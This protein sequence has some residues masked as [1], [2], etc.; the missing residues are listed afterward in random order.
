MGTRYSIDFNKLFDEND[1]EGM[2]R[3]AVQ[4]LTFDY[5]GQK[6][7]PHIAYERAETCLIK[8]AEKGYRDAPYFLAYQ[9][10]SGNLFKRD[11]KKALYWYEKAAEQGN[12]WSAEARKRAAVLKADKAFAI[13]MRTKIIAHNVGAIIAAALFIACIHYA[14]WLA[15][16]D[17]NSLLEYLYIAIG[18]VSG[19]LTCGI[20]LYLVGLDLTDAQEFAFPGAIIGL[21]AGFVIPVCF[22]N[23]ALVCKVTTIFFAAL[24]LLMLVRIFTKKT[25]YLR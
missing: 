16:Y 1:L 7:F 4:I 21:I 2:Y 6:S 23:N 20:C 15:E 11:K 25:H 18:I 8:A 3:F 9:Y 24:S 13:S 12:E 10:E 14:R 22:Y 19:P 17:G 5:I